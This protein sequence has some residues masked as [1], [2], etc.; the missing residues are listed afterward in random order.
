MKSFSD[1]QLMPGINE[2]TETGKPKSKSR[3]LLLKLMGVGAALS[4]GKLFGQQLTCPED[5]DWLIQKSLNLQ[6]S[7]ALLVYRPLDLLFLE[8]FFVNYEKTTTNTITKKTSGTSYLIVNFQPQSIAEEA[9]Q[10]NAGE[11]KPGE[12]DIYAFGA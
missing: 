4:P 3:R 1:F 10:E 12:P 9:F 6:N 8:L 7:V 5:A 11:K 2:I